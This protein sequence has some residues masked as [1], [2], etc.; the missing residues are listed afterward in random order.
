MP[1]PDRPDGMLGD[2]SASD[3]G[4]SRHGDAYVLTLSHRAPLRLLPGVA[5]RSRAAGN[6]NGHRDIPF[7]G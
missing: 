1:A 2:R 6:R 7:P 5:A 4:T 3:S